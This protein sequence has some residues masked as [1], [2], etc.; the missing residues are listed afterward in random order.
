MYIKRVLLYLIGGPFVALVLS[1]GAFGQAESGT[2]TGTV[3]DPSG[4]VVA[5][6]TVTIRNVA[7]SATRT[8]QTT[9]LGT[10][11]VTGLQAR[12]YEV[13][14]TNRNVERQKT[15]TQAMTDTALT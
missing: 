15:R 8:V 13:D 2:I 1:S 3:H 12:T 6:A 4:A 9:A 10:Y 14:V 11:N 5:G 7:T